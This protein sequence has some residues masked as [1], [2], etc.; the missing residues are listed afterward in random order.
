MHDL[1]VAFW[2]SFSQQLHEL[3]KYCDWF[4]G[5]GFKWDQCSNFVRKCLSVSI[6][7]GGACLLAVFSVHAFYSCYHKK[8]VMHE[9]LAVFWLSSG[10]QLHE[11][12]KYCN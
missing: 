11:L 6:Q 3:F 8:L 1:L 12:F 7:T 5:T 10:Q 9:L 2:L 4:I